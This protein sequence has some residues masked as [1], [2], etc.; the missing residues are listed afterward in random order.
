MYGMSRSGLF[1]TCM[2]EI[3]KVKVEGGDGHLPDCQGNKSTETTH[4]LHHDTRRMLFMCVCTLLVS[5]E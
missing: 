2:S 3:E 5:E 1:I 4:G